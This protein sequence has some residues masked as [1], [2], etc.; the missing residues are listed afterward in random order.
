MKGASHRWPKTAIIPCPSDLRTTPGCSLEG[1]CGRTKSYTF[2]S[3][4]KQ[5]VVYLSLCC[6]LFV[7]FAML[8]V[9]P[10]LG[11]EP[12]VWFWDYTCTCVGCVLNSSLLHSYRRIPPYLLCV[13]KILKTR[14]STFFVLL[15][16]GSSSFRWVPQGTEQGREQAQEEWATVVLCKSTSAKT[17]SLRPYTNHSESTSRVYRPAK[18]SLLKQQ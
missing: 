8:T 4:R 2:R 3:R 6:L 1:S 15:F 18:N 14:L 5:A 13:V 7:E 12:S 11:R 16:K 9:F 10:D 17:R